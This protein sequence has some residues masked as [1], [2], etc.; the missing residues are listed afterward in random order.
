MQLLCLTSVLQFL[1]DHPDATALYID[2]EGAFSPERAY[3]SI[4][5]IIDASSA[6]VTDAPQPR[7]PDAEVWLVLDRL[8]VSTAMEVSNVLQA[9][10]QF[11]SKS[12]DDV[13][14]SLSFTKY[15]GSHAA[16][17]GR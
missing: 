3:A 10:H 15:D 8:T 14:W 4:K 7:I 11:R 2:T 9:L 6:G 5:V 17:V 1:I 13:S 16:P 12:K